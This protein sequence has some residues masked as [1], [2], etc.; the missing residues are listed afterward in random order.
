MATSLVRWLGTHLGVNGLSCSI[1]PSQPAQV[2]LSKATKLK[3]VTLKCSLRPGW[4]LK[5]L[6]TVACDHTELERIVLRVVSSQG[7]GDSQDVKYAVGESAYR[8]WLELDRVLAQLCES[9]SIRVKVVCDGSADTDESRE[10]R[11]M[12]VLLPEA[13]A[14]GVVDLVEWRE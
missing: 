13:M 5:T 10:R 8:E 2:N 12:E 9:Q 3:D 6:R 1:D 14:R 11:R 7:L 4:I